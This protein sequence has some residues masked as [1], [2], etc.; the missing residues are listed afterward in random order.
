MRIDR[1]SAGMLLGAA[2]IFAGVLLTQ[3][4]YEAFFL[5]AGGVAALATTA[6]RRWQRGN[7]PEKDERTN[8]IRAFGLAYSWLVSMIL[9]LFSFC[10]TIMGFIS[11]DAITALSIT[12]YIMAGSAIV[13]LAVLHRRG[14]V[15]WS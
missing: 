1:F 5:V 9:V 15:D 12:I 8:K 14:D 10:A 13:S 3:A 6:V 11:I 2:L 7:E 4:G